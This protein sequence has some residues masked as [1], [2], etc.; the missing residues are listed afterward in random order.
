MNRFFVFLEG[1]VLFGIVTSSAAQSGF[2]D[3]F[4]SRALMAWDIEGSR[5]W[6]VEDGKVKP[7][8]GNEDGFLIGSYPCSDN[9]TIEVD[10]NADLWNGHNGGVVF[11]YNSPSFFYYIAVKPGNQWDDGLYFCVNTTDINKGQIIARNLNVSNQFRLKIEITGQTFNIFINNIF[12]GTASDNSIPYGLIGLAHS[13]YW[14]SIIDFD[15]F[16]WTDQPGSFSS[17]PAENPF[18]QPEAGSIEVY[19][20]DEA[21][22]ESNILKPRWY[23]KNNGTKSI[24]NFKVYYYITATPG[25]D[26]M[27]D[28]YY[29]PDCNVSLDRIT[30]I[31]YRLTLDYS[32]KT[33]N[34]GQITPDLSGSV[35][36]I[37]YS[38]FSIPIDKSLSFSYD[39]T[40]SF[41]LNPNAP[42]MMPDSPVPISGTT[43]PV[44]IKTTT[45][46][47]TKLHCSS[48]EDLTGDECILDVYRDGSVI[49]T[50][51]RDMEDGNDWSLNEEFPLKGNMQI[52]LTDEDAGGPFDQNDFLGTVVISNEIG[53]H[54]GKFNQDGTDYT[55]Y[56]E[57]IEN[58][59]VVPGTRVETIKTLTINSLK[60]HD[61]EDYTFS[62][63]LLLRVSIDKKYVSG[64]TKKMQDGDL[65]QIGASYQMDSSASLQLFE[66][67]ALDDDDT[68]GTVILD[69]SEGTHS[70]EFT[71]HSHYTVNYTVSES[72]RI[73]P[74]KTDLEMAIENFEN[75]T[76]PGL[77]P[78]IDKN[79]LIDDIKRK[80]TN[81]TADLPSQAS[82]P[83]CGLAAIMY[84]LIKQNPVKFVE[85]CQRIY[86][87][88][89]F[90]ARTKTFS[91]TA[92]Q[93]V[94][95]EALP[96]IFLDSC[97]ISDWMFMAFLR[98]EA[99]VMIDV[100]ANYNWFTQAYG[101]T[102]PW[103]MK[104]WTYE[105][106]GFNNIDI[107]LSMVYGEMDILNEASNIVENNGVA[108]L[109]VDGDYFKRGADPT[110]SLPTHWVALT[111]KATIDWGKWYSWDSGNVKFQI[112][113][114][115]RLMDIDLSE[116]EFEDLFF[117]SVTGK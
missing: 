75:S 55:L 76:K 22:T 70:G 33:L 60:C 11:R 85:I 101:I 41:T 111:S 92:D 65:W 63:D 61:Q 71:H 28:D 6:S 102:T 38:D 93:D 66:I 108:F 77:W 21:I 64:L 37:Y 56:Y 34:P 52:T 8:T 40:P 79:M 62:D 99:N 42:V 112:F 87:D 113:T 18:T 9:G 2:S 80:V 45:L 109:L 3:G 1:L 15:N 58:T 69:I 107:D 16:S 114:W 89:S 20:K 44:T 67:D 78:H 72:Q 106:L 53:S 32:G 29:T 73:V 49:K 4:S 25:Y 24:K 12:R 91:I 74:S 117:G 19:T 51:N 59:E 10:V 115:A 50:F 7:K 86:E 105:L 97:D 26:L 100:R 68:L 81:D 96:Q 35:V 54:E 14:E 84:S 47:L 110:L 103:E 23:I 17:I 27:L 5:E 90:P 46:R 57:V 94:L 43:P 104:E 31:K 82:T 88:L 13:T 116:G 30:D 36:G 48:S 95:Q 83:M 98:D 39:S